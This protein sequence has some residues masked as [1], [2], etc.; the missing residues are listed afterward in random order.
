MRCALLYSYDPS[1]TGPGEDESRSGSRSTSRSGRRAPSSTRPASTP[2]S[3]RRR[4]AC[5]TGTSGRARAWWSARQGEVLAGLYVVDVPEE[6][7]A[8]EWAQRVPTAGY[9]EVEIRPA[10]DFG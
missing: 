6:A 1:Q 4:W 8:R 10:V 9:G 7:A 2:P 5:A 3:R